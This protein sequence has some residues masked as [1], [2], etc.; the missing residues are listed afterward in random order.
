M[1]PPVARKI[2]LTFN[3]LTVRENELDRA[4]Q[5]VAIASTDVEPH[6]RKEFLRNSWPDRESSWE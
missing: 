5:R 3:S 1:P 6:M 4:P 2:F